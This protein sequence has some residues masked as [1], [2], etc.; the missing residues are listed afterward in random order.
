M[1]DVAKF[2]NQIKIDKIK[3]FRMYNNIYSFYLEL[4]NAYN[5]NNIIFFTKIVFIIS[6]ISRSIT[7]QSVTQTVPCNLN[8]LI[9]V[10]GN[11]QD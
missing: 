9:I 3:L 7:N 6:C 1:V 8:R 2:F 10:D 5:A 4:R 11:I